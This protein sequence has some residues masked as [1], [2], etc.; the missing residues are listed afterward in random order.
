MRLTRIAFLTLFPL[1]LLAGLA[2]AWWVEPARVAVVR[3]DLRPK[4]T[5][6]K[7]TISGCHTL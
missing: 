2:Y 4:A 1:T 3:H 6:N 5:L 7:S